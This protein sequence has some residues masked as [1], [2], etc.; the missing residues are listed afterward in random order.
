MRGSSF[1][2]AGSSFKCAGSS[3]KYAGSSFA[4]DV[5]QNWL[6][7]KDIKK[8]KNTNMLMYSDPSPEAP[9]RSCY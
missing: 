6:L 5:N 7:G 4:Q 8:H 2:Y 9:G 3:F 1:K